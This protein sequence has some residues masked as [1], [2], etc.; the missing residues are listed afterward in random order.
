MIGIAFRCGRVGDR[1]P[2]SARL[3]CLSLRT[4]T[5]VGP[6]NDDGQR[7]FSVSGF[8]SVFSVRSVAYCHSCGCKKASVSASGLPGAGVYSNSQRASGG[9]DIKMASM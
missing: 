9:S 2:T 6:Y 7:R 1:A 8:P 4:D 3:H 5:L